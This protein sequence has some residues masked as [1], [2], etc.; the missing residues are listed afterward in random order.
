MS[1]TPNQHAESALADLI[2]RLEGAV[3]RLGVMAA[4]ERWPYGDQ[5]RLKGKIQGLRIAL[6]YAREAAQSDGSP[7]RGTT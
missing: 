2:E 1:E 7:S 6:S 5:M 3:Y 4:D